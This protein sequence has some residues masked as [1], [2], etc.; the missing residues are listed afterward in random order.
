MSLQGIILLR[1]T[2]LL[3]R[4]K[5]SSIKTKNDCIQTFLQGLTPIECT[6][7]SLWKATKKIKQVK[8]APSPL[9]T[10]QGTWAR[11]NVNKAHAFTEHL[12][13]VF[14]PHPSKTEPQKEEALIQ[15]LEA[16][17]QVKPP[18]NRLKRAEVREVSSLNPKKSSGYDLITGKIFKILPNVGVKY[19]T[20][21]FSAVL[22]KGYF[23]AQWKVAQIILILKPRK[24]PNKLTSYRPISFLPIISKK[25]K[26]LKRSPS[27]G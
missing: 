4:P 25:F 8:K 27:K 20:Q 9:R 13:E 10:L 16:P 17:Y 12:A 19:L 24:P 1:K 22:L 14:Q 26:A 18:I 7:Y 23:L 2:C 5:N 11:S 6:D 15:F 21:L 3:K